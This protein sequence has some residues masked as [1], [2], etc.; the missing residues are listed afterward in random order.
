MASTIAMSG[1]TDRVAWQRVEDDRQVIDYF[2]TGGRLRRYAISAP[3]S[4][5][6]ILR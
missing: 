2:S 6:E 5:A 4:G 3:M 1:K